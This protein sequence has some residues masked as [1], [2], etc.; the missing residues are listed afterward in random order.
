MA[1]RKGD[2]NVRSL[3]PS[4]SCATKVTNFNGF[5][6][7]GVFPLQGTVKNAMEHFFDDAVNPFYRFPPMGMSLDV[8][9]CSVVLNDNDLG[10]FVRETAD[11][12]FLAWLMKY[13]SVRLT[14]GEKKERFHESA[15]HIAI[16]FNFRA[17][18]DRGCTAH[19]CCREDKFCNPSQRSW[20]SCAS[21][22]LSPQAS[23]P[24]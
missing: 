10:T 3:H 24:Q 22:K 16:R 17:S 11:V 14:S 6:L 1:G 18:E 20:S 15:K 13:D 21:H 4:P 19:R 5:C 12:F 7:P 8:A 2:S 9:F 23:W